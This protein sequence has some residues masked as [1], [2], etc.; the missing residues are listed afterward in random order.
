MKSATR[1]PFETH[2]R[3]AGMA[4]FFLFLLTCRQCYFTSFGTQMSAANLLFTYLL[5]VGTNIL[6]LL[7]GS[8]AP[9]KKE[10][11]E[12][13]YYMLVNVYYCLAPV[14]NAS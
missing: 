11:V 1:Y 13:A 7:G 3:A 8:D 5:F 9:K 12:A 6:I 10:L 14:N 4:G 2:T